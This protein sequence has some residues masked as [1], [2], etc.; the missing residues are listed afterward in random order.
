MQ[1]SCPRGSFVVVIQ[2][3]SSVQLFMTPWTAALQAPLSFTISRSLL[4]FM[5]IEWVMKM[6]MSSRPPTRAYH[7]TW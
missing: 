4:K 6:G 3:L 5:S 1:T 7:P 2:P